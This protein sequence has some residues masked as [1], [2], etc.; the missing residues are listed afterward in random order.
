MKKLIYPLLII[1]FWG[2]SH[3]KTDPIP[4][5]I[6]EME[7]LTVYS[8]DAKPAAEI[9]IKK[10][11]LYGGSNEVFIGDLGE[12]AVDS[13]G[14]VFIE[15][16]GNLFIHVFEPFGRYLG[17]FGRDGRGPGEF[18]SIKS[19]QIRDDQLYVFDFR[20]NRVNI[21]N[22]NTLVIEETISLARN[23]GDH[24]ELRGSYPSV[25]EFYAGSNNTYI[26][27]FISTGNSIKSD[28]ENI[29][30]KGLLYLM[31]DTGDLSEKLVDFKDAI[32]TQ[33]PVRNTSFDIPLTPF[34]GNTL[35]AFSG[36]NSMYQAGP[37]HFLITVYSPNGRYERAFYYPFKKL[38]L[39]RE[40]A[41]SGEVLDELIINPELIIQNINS[42]D[43]PETW[44]VLTNM[45][46]D[47]E[48]R[49]WVSTIVKDFEIYEWW[50]LEV[51][52][53][54]ITTFEWPRN[55]P[56]EVIKNGKMYTRQTDEETGLQQVVR[57]RVEME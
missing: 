40:S 45:L 51:S 49:L 23:R 5:E 10:D 54:L 50:V 57:Y 46:M 9:S 31:D 56:I 43:L 7:N 22:L 17:H 34:F 55:E 48:N 16:T 33:F 32:R 8:V 20:Q 14:R 4:E 36:E 29:E 26:V 28:W 25:D 37:D 44:P 1:V 38:L 13:S 21:F 15:D 39:T 2:C 52:G 3:Q 30:V 18:S 42:V 53:E 12:I 6:Q 11:V 35:I 27:K 24:H 19:L 41:I 47:D